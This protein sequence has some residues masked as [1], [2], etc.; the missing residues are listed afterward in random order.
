MFGTFL[1]LLSV[2]PEDAPNIWL[3][4]VGSLVLGI[5]GLAAFAGGVWKKHLWLFALA[6]LLFVIGPTWL[7][8]A[9]MSY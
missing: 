8:V 1:T 3:A 2:T 7:W 4:M 6:G 9:I 5:A